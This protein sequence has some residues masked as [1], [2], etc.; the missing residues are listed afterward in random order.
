M[1][2]A[3]AIAIA[4][5]AHTPVLVH[6]SRE[7][8]PLASVAAADVSAPALGR[9]RRP[10][11][12]G[13]AVAA[14]ARA[15]WLQ[16]WLFYAEQDQDRGILRSGRH[17][18]DWEV[19]QYQLDS[20]GHPVEAVYSQH[21]G[22]E[23]CSWQTVRR[24]EGRPLVYVAR[25]SHA[26]YLRPG[27][28]DRMWPDPNDE[29]NGRG[30]LVKPRLVRI[31]QRPP[32]WLGWP[33]RW[34]GARARWWVPPEQDSPRGP[35]FQGQGRWSDPQSWARAARNCQARCDRVGECDRP[36]GLLAGGAAIAA[37]AGIAFVGLRRRRRQ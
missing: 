3:S 15:T 32:R 23:R 5:V 13:R 17:A 28:R 30:R 2:T 8:Y 27:T 7:R 29:A 35:A 12:Y 18:G 25:G 34:G 16:Y 10:T 11:V 33:G 31:D 4:L 14:S 20:R 26:S 21:S 36:E 19:V 9:D 24:R 1:L 37:V 22:A 6:D